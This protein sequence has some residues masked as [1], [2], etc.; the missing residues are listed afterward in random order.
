LAKIIIIPSTI[1]MVVNSTLYIK[2]RGYDSG[3]LEVAIDPIWSSSMGILPPLRAI[4]PYSQPRTSK[5]TGIITATVSMITGTVNVTLVP[6]K[7]VELTVSPDSTDVVAG[8]YKVFEAHAYDKFKNGPISFP[9]GRRTWAAWTIT[10][11]SPKHRP[12]PGR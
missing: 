2:A 12:G 1:N 5:G 6:D 4:R 7:T 9:T 8:R 10:Y 11:I 3:D